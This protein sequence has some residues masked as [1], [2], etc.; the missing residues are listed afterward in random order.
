MRVIEEVE[1]ARPVE[2][3][4]P[5]TADLS[6]V[7]EW[8]PSVSESRREGDEYVLV[9]KFLGKRVE[10]R[11]RITER[12]ENRRFVAEGRSRDTATFEARDGRTHL[13][14]QVELK[15]PGLLGPLMRRYARRALAGLKARLEGR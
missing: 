8:D 4:F 3:V 5:Y 6:N 2:E 1:I 12:E 11:Y 14:W 10:L 9:A 13:T 7:S 15:A